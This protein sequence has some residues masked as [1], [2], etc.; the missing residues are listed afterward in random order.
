M[1][2][3]AHLIGERLALVVK[4]DH[5][6][7]EFEKVHDAMPLLATRVA[8]IEE[9]QNNHPDTHRLEGIA[10]EVARRALD[11]K[12]HTMNNLK[13]QIDSERNTFITRELYD[14]EHRR[15]Q[16]DIANLRASRD[17]DTGVNA[18]EK[19]LLDR[20]WPILLGVVA[21]LLGHFWK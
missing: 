6:E 4:L 17:T 20:F 5:L 14:R 16:D 12:L 1:V 21:L 8:L 18:S 13:A 19:S 9:W 7:S 2:E 15:M 11:E 3:N 10:L